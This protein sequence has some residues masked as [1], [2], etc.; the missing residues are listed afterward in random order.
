MTEDQ[1][2]IQKIEIESFRKTFRQRHGIN[3]YV[4]MP[5]QERYRI[6]LD[7]FLEITLEC[8]HEHNPEHKWI[9]SIKNIALRKRS[10]VKWVQIM[11]YIAWKDGHSKSEIGRAI[12]KN[13]ATV[14][15]SCRNVEDGMHVGDKIVM[16]TYNIIINKIVEY[17]GTV[18]EN[19]ENKNNSKSSTDPIWDE[20]RRFL[21]YSN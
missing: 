9:K 6:P 11:C 10:Y 3:L 4:Y 5:K 21:A 18:P 20:A 8:I 16:E 2:I 15:N 7:T 12:G 13:H 1:E 19:L 14:I 17:V